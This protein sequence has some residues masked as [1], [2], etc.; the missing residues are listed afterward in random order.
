LQLII[1]ELTANGVMEARRLW[2]SPFTD[3][4]PQGPT[5][6]FSEEQVDGIVLVIDEIR[7]HAAAGETVA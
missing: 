4:A 3:N 6:L 5:Y 1:A 7:A 2:E